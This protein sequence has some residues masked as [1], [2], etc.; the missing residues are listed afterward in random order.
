[1][2]KHIL[3]TAST[4]PSSSKDP[5]PTFVKD[6][7]VA[8]KEQDP[9]LRF[10][11]LA[12]HDHRSSTKDFSKHKE[13]DEYRFHYMW[14]RSL[15][16]L[17]G[18]GGIVP[19]LKQ[20][21]ALYLVVPFFLLA[22]FFAVVRLT[23][24][25]K[26]DLVNAHWIIPQGFVCALASL[27]TRK[28]IVSTVHGGDVFTFNNKPAKAVK[29]FVLKRSSIV[30]V[31]SS[32]T[33]AQSLDLYK[34]ANYQ[35]IPMGVTINQFA[36]SRA[37][38]KSDTLRLLF[39]GRVTEEKGIQYLLRS[40]PIL[41]ERGIPF[42]ATIVGTGPYDQLLQKEA[43]D[44]GLADDVTFTGWVEQ[45]NI[46]SYYKNSDIFVGPSVQSSNGW[47]EAL[48]VVF[49]EASSAGLPIIATRSGGIVDIVKDGQTGLLVK[50]RSPEEIANA[51]EKLKNNELRETLGIQA[52]KHV[53]ENYSWESVGKKYVS[54]IQQLLS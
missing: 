11:V 1:M 20:N 7:V 32:A 28:K 38:S 24:R 47:Q 41:K 46:A 39:V 26:P 16:R 29:R 43:D 4:F 15:E 44:L 12:P 52:K 21:P 31:N 10:S 34:S 35:I 42:T 30:V 22:Q 48:G 6:L 53:T 49:L 17:A 2:K 40:L 25:L 13:Y 3:V 5:V 18:Q 36:G 54:V 14:P 33:K 8:M 51:I 9:E 19:T 27:I 50:Q 45:K 37:A 23:F